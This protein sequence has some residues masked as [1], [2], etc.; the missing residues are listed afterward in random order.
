VNIERNYKLNLRKSIAEE[1]LL[2]SGQFGLFYIVMQF[3]IERRDF[4]HDTGHVVLLTVL[5]VQAVLLG[6][7]GG[8][9]GY[10]ILLAFLV[11]V[12]YSIFEY[13]EG[14]SDFLN[15]AHL[16]FWL[17]AACSSLLMVLRLRNKIALKRFAEITLVFM[18]VLIFL[19]LYFYFDTWKEIRD[20]GELVISRIFTHL[21]PFLD[22]PTHWFVIIGGIFLASTIAYDRNDITRLKDRIN[23]LFGK[24][25]DENIRD[26]I[27]QKGEYS[28]RR[29]NLCI[30]FSDIK[31]FTNMCE[32]HD[33]GSIGNML[34]LYFEY[35]NTIVRKNHGTVDKYIGDAIMV[36]FGLE[37]HAD[38]CDSAAGC[39]FEA[40]A[41]F[42][43]LQ[44]E[45]AQKSLP[46]PSGFGIGCHYG[47]LIIG[48]IG[49]SERKNFTVVGDTVNIA[50]RL[51]SATR[52]VD[53][54]III[55]AGMYEHLNTDNKGR[56][57]YIGKVELK[58]K[59]EP[60]GIWGNK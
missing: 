44:R 43:T 33:A 30:L 18:N 2:Y 59:S 10:R 7:F 48:D 29:K 46:V 8:R 42:K 11:P 28:A 52:N 39:A 25:V 51:E 35:W 6:R 21:K 26:M 40:Q 20:P 17:Y 22:D 45:L 23:G 41:G 49:S 58:G 54:D 24:Y 1:L 34:N 27:I 31:S 16:G 4:F 3:I 12:V 55:S 37:N 53:N 14:I 9:P 56:F 60:L 32:L 13:A 19:F 36:I 50:S 38:A 15:T 57:N 5:I 47:E